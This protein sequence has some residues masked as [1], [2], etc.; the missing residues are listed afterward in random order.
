MFPS[1]YYFLLLFSTL[2]WGFIHAHTQ[3][4]SVLMLAYS[5][6]FQRLILL[7]FIFCLPI[8]GQLMFVW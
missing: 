6:A 7:Q 4:S 8:D 2:V 5:M 1:A 3:R